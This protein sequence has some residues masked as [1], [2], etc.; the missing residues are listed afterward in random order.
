MNSSLL[1]PSG[2]YRSLRSFQL[3]Q[4]IFDITVHFVKLY[5]PQNSRT[6]DQMTQAARSGVQNI[7][8]GSV[9]SATSKKTELKLTNVARA[10]L[11]ELKLDYEDYLRQHGLCRWSKEHPLYREFVA[12]RIGTKRQFREFVRRAM[13]GNGLQQTTTDRRIAASATVGRC[14]LKSVVVANATLLLLR[15][16]DYLL[17]RQIQRQAAD[18]EKNGGFTERLYRIRSEKRDKNAGKGTGK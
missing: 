11:E 10:S 18:F 8:E 9:A 13:D 6:C 7:A 16:A 5:I 3:A 12:L 1:P 17:M 4:L 14:P 2:G 15:S